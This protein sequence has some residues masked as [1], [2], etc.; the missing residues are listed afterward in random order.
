MASCMT[1]QLN[2]N[3]WHCLQGSGVEAD[4]KQ[5][6]DS[7]SVGVIISEETRGKDIKLEVHPRRMKLTIHGDTA[8]EGDFKEKVEPD[9]SFFSIEEQNDKRMCL[10]TLDKKDMGHESWKEFFAEDA[11][12]DS[13]THKARLLPEL[14]L[15]K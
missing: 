5:S 10:I 4:W 6:T 9:G 13:V 14:L 2:C 3:V 1:S 12:D 11:I 8:L 15:L 7:I